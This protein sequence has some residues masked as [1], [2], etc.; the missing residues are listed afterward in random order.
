MTNSLEETKTNRKRPHA[1]ICL[2][3]LSSLINL[4]HTPCSG[5]WLE[6]MIYFFIS[7]SFFL[8]FK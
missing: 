2:I 8:Y 7:N 4:D 6:E 3:R 1:P 5:S